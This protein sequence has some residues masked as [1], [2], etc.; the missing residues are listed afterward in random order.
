MSQRRLVTEF[1]NNIQIDSPGTIDLRS[2]PI[3]NVPDPINNLDAVNKQYLAKFIKVGDLKW[4]IMNNDNNGYLVC[5]GRSLSTS[6]YAELYS[7][8]GTTFGSGSGTFN[9][10][11]ARSRTLGAVGHGSG[12]TNRTTGTN[13]GNETETLT[14]NEL[15][16]HTH[17]GTTST[18]ANHDHGGQTGS[19][20]SAPE[21]ESCAS[22]SGVVMSGSG[23]HVHGISPDGA[24]NHTF[25]T[26][27]TGTGAAFSLF[28][29]TIFIGNVLIFTN[30]F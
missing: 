27:S 23:S 18:S 13:I 6:T 24:H 10:P 26:N 11:D 25:T 7:V 16:S 19:G 29:P 20:G 21:S 3:I 15:P 22:G 8:I 14:T 5:D 17:T 30:V 2:N 9:L 4:S 12:L 28:Q 1:Y